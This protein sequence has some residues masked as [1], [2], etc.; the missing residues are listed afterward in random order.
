MGGALEK[1]WVGGLGESWGSLE[2]GLLK[3]VRG[4][5]GGRS[6]RVWAEDVVLQGCQGFWWSGSSLT[7]LDFRLRYDIM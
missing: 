3:S 5:L 7:I 6:G 2:R 1:C 4:G